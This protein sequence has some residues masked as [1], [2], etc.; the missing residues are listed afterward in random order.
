[1]ASERSDKALSLPDK[2]GP[3][4]SSKNLLELLGY[5]AVKVMQP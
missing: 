4:L 1:M 5:K 3:Q 2:V